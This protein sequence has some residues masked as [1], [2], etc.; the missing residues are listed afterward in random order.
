MDF[1]GTFIGGVWP[2]TRGGSGVG[3]TLISGAG[4]IVSGSFGGDVG[5]TLSSELE[6]VEGRRDLGD[7]VARC[8]I[9]ATW[10][11]VFLIVEP[12]VSGEFFSVFDCK[13]LNISSSVCLR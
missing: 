9:W 10:I 12:M 11:N 8:R 3:V 6:M 5:T 13:I 2:G 4:V 1:K 7:A